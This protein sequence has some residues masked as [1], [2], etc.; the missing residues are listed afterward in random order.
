VATLEDKIDFNASFTIVSYTLASKMGSL[1]KRM[2]FQI[3][4]ADEAHYLKSRDS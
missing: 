1:I 2:K 3:V 4:I